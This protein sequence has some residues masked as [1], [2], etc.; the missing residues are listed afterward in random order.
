MT[1]RVAV[2]VT[3]M[4]IPRPCLHLAGSRARGTSTTTTAARKKSR[5]TRLTSGSSP[6]TQMRT[7]EVVAAVAAAMEAMAAAAVVAAAAAVV[8]AAATR[9]AAAAAV[10][11]R[12]TRGTQ[13]WGERST[14]TRRQP[15]A[16]EAADAAARGRARAS[17]RGGTSS[18]KI[19]CGRG[20]KN[21]GAFGFHRGR[22]AFMVE[23]L[24]CTI[25]RCLLYIVGVCLTCAFAFA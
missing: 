22:F 12:K 4:V 15:R 25:R 21:N 8:A 14:T 2:T 3:V 6:G 7:A 24:R 17:R 19:D 13:G 23:R 16:S 18:S 11:P 5:W 20:G 10:L 9:G 1:A